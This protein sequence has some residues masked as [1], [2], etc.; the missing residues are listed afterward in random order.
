MPNWL[1]ILIILL[2]V[3]ALFY[4]VTMLARGVKEEARLPAGSAYAAEGIDS[5]ASG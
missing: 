5:P 2:C 3:V 4:L 1:R